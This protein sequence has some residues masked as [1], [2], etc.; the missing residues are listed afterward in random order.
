MFG[1]A[2][3]LVASA[4]WCS[5]S[6]DFIIVLELAISCLIEHFDVF[7]YSLTLL[8]IHLIRHILANLI[9]IYSVRSRWFVG[10]S[11]GGGR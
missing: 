10:S 8:F 11:S 6:L 5:S 7:G 2:E 1:G 9:N 4:M 3:G